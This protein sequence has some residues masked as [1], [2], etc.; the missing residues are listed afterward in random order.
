MRRFKLTIVLAF[1][2]VSMLMCSA[3]AAGQTVCNIDLP[4][5]VIASDGRVLQGLK[6]ELLV[7]TA[8]KTQ[9]Q[10]SNLVPESGPRR[11]LFVMELGRDVPIPAR[12]AMTKAVAEIL[13]EARPEDSF[14]LVTTRG[15]QVEVPLGR[16]RARFSEALKVAEGLRGKDAEGVLDTL[17]RATGWFQNAQPGDAILVFTL[18]LEGQ[19]SVAY[20][21]VVN[22]L[23]LR[24]IRVFGFLFG[25][26]EEGSFNMVITSVSP[27]GIG[28]ITG[29]VPNRESIRDLSWGSGGYYVQEATD[30][31]HEYK[32]TDTNLQAIRTK[33]SRIYSAVTEYYRVTVA[34]GAQPRELSLSL[35]DGVRKKAPGAMVLY[36][37]QL[38]SCGP[39][40]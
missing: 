23:N 20:S 24:G 32:A 27:S 22:A 34:L 12:T 28:S 15:A 18:G 38:P 31:Q 9:A 10:I 19:H 6:P 14:G 16:D 30:P 35:A 4:V 2:I 33:A 21:R 8:K 37:R 11:V 1:E 13:A 7:V 26:L 39:P 25:S 17:S 3:R 5:N 29:Y 40:R 36:P